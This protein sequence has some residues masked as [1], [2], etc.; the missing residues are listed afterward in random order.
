MVHLFRRVALLAL[1]ALP[2]AIPSLGQVT[3]EVGNGTL[4]KMFGNVSLTN[5]TGHTSLAIDDSANA[6]SDYLVIRE[7]ERG[8][9]PV[10][11]GTYKDT[12][13]KRDAVW[14]YRRKELV[15]NIAG[16]MALKNKR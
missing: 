6:V 7:S 12:F 2:F 9:I 16:D 3:I 1:G 14:R 4:T 13:I 10:M 11:G 8:L 15:H 5:A